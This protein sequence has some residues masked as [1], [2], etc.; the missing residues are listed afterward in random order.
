[1]PIDMAAVLTWTKELLNT[2]NHYC[3]LKEA[4]IM[5]ASFSVQ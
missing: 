2:G 3:T 4:I 1:M 5:I